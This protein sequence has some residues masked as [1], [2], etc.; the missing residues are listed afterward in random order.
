M[1]RLFSFQLSDISLNS[2]A[3]KKQGLGRRSWG[4]NLSG[5][6]GSGER[7]PDGRIAPAG[8]GDP[9]K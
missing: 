2:F 7:N 4:G 6:A 8:P 3:E 1:S 9:S 5:K